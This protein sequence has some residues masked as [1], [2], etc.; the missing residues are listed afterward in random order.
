MQLDGRRQYYCNLSEKVTREVYALTS[1]SRLLKLE[2][3]AGL[4]GVLRLRDYLLRV[5]FITF[6]EG[7]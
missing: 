4:H 5:L 2:R 1:G 7:M 3:T 6:K